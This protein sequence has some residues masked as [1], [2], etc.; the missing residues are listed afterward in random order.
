M[1]KNTKK[2]YNILRTIVWDASAMCCF[3][4]RTPIPTDLC[5]DL[6]QFLQ[7]CASPTGNGIGKDLTGLLW[8]RQLH[9]GIATLLMAERGVVLGEVCSH[10][11][12]KRPK[13]WNRRPRWH[14]YIKCCLAGVRVWLGNWR[15]ASQECWFNR[16]TY[17]NLV[18][19][20]LLLSVAMV[21]WDMVGII[22]SHTVMQTDT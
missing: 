7:I 2:A 18:Y 9:Q 20:L 13:I 1:A 5:H 17:M 6:W 8:R 12:W 14:I 22:L 19:F 4:G 10:L 15:R 21:G 11:M 3:S 16:R